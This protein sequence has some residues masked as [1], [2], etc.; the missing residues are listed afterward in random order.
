MNA[1]I[2][3][4]F[5]E[6]IRLLRQAQGLPP[7]LPQASPPAQKPCAL[8]L[9]ELPPQ[10]STPVTVRSYLS[11]PSVEVNEKVEQKQVYNSLRNI[12]KKLISKK[13]RA[14]KTLK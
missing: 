13:Y 14:L 11:S 9:P 8:T 5:N 2:N 7:A 3:A 1:N 12:R 4:K 10:P 6:I